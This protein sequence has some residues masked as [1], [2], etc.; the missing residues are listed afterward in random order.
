MAD[1]ASRE[2]LRF[3]ARIVADSG[4]F[5]NVPFFSA[6]KVR[7]FTRKVRPMNQIFVSFSPKSQK[8]DLDRLP[9]NS[10]DK[11]LLRKQR[12]MA[13]DPTCSHCDTPLT[14]EPHRSDSCHLVEDSLSC[15]GCVDTVR[16]ISK[17]LG[18]VRVDLTPAGAAYAKRQSRFKVKNDRKKLKLALLADGNGCDHCGRELTAVPDRDDS[19]HLIV[20]RLA[21]LDHIKIVRAYSQLDQQE[22]K[23]C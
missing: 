2:G 7:A 12:L 13:F 21:C 15:P 16:Q 3:S 5:L 1:I 17:S 23:A 10:R 9:V 20:D 22:A 8:P 14:L 4:Q 18:G 19:A 11:R 6:P